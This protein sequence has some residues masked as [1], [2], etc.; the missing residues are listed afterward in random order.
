MHHLTMVLDRIFGDQHGH[1]HAADDI[2]NAGRSET[3]LLE[4]NAVF[5]QRCIDHH[6]PINP[7]KYVPIASTTYCWGFMIDSEGY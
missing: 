7:K 4:R 2:R 5:L 1:A 6:D 3:E